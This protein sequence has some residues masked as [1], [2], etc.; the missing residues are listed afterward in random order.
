MKQPISNLCLMNT[1]GFGISDIERFI[2]GM[3]ILFGNMA[4]LLVTIEGMYKVPPV[5]PP[6]EYS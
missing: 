6:L 3:G 2:R 5:P 1:A 4:G